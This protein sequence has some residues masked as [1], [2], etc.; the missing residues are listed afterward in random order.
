MRILGKILNNA[1]K[2]K[3]PVIMLD[4]G[5]GTVKV[6][7]I[8]VDEKDNSK[9]I[10]IGQGISYQ[11]PGSDIGGASMD[12]PQILATCK[13]A[14]D[15]AYKREDSTVLDAVVGISGYVSRTAVANIIYKRVHPEKAITEDELKNIFEEINGRVIK[16]TQEEFVSVSRQDSYRL[17]NIAIVEIRIDGYKV[18]VPLGFQGKEMNFRIITVY[19]PA[20]YLKIINTI[21]FELR[22]NVLNTFSLP[23]A[24][25]KIYQNTA[26]GFGGIIIDVGYETTTVSVVQDNAMAGIKTFSIGGAA[27][28]R[29][30]A[31]KLN[32]DFKAAEDMKI[33]YGLRKLLP[34]SDEK[35]SQ[36]L[37]NIVLL[38]YRGVK[39]SLLDFSV[40]ELVSGKIYITGGGS[41]L[42]E[43]SKVLNTGDLRNNLP[44]IEMICVNQLNPLAEAGNIFS[45]SYIDPAEFNGAISLASFFF[46][47]SG[48]KQNMDK[49]LL[50][51]I[52]NK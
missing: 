3:K 22:L 27:F 10:I 41:V 28:T 6:L 1:E 47:Y 29:T 31:R 16:K 51:K 25:A 4:I 36:I 38:W 33:Q 40:T 48:G 7:A 19:A 44:I 37:N 18:S 17:L 20:S 43:I 9:G 32:L 45:D 15:K 23:F 35:V 8:K 30:I 52:E 50:E 11:S 34:E 2:T 42:P 13:E 49:F 24:M 14:L 39:K 21:A 5:E 26:N 12:F 46:N